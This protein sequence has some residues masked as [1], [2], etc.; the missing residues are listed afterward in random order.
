VTSP[1]TELLPS[2]LLPELRHL[3]A[4]LAAELPYR[5]AAELLRELLPETGGITAM[6]T[7]SRTLAIG[8]AMEAELCREVEQPQM[9]QD[10]ADHLTVGID[11]GVCQSEA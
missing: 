4:K 1:L 2:R 7:R 5:R 9:S 3:Q 11:G 8:M 6:T 10:Q